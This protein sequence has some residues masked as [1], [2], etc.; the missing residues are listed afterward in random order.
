VRAERRKGREACDGREF[1]TTL[2]L[3]YEIATN[4]SS[5]SRFDVWS[6]WIANT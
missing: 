3:G 1:L 5:K 4:G 6:V 2:V